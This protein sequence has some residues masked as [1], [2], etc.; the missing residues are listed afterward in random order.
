MVR[1]LFGGIILGGLDILVIGWFW[2]LFK[3]EDKLRATE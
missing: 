1:I 3:C 2:P